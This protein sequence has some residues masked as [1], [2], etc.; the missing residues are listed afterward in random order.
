MKGQ[1]NPFVISGYEGAKYFC[2]RVDETAQMASEIANGNNI[3]LIAT[4]R[5]GKSGLI[6]HYFTQQEV[7]AQYYTFFVDIYDTQ[8]LSELI[9]R[10]S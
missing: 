9:L 7:Q 8:S 4:R 5:M 10:L 1:A 6:E 3:A 2:D